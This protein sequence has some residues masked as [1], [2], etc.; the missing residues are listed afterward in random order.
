LLAMLAGSAFGMAHI[1]FPYV[2]PVILASAV[3][4]GLLVALAPDLPIAVGAGVI[5]A[6]AI[7]HGHAHGSEVAE[8][9]GGFEYMAGFTLATAA[10]HLAGFGF[11][12]AMNGLSLQP[13]IR[14]SG[15]V[16]VLIGACLFIQ[17]L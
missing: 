4:I 15:G 17:L 9:I 1:A 7:F 10:L 8:S 16:C 12:R 13:A 11:A 14:I 5:A 6:F 2:E 3:A